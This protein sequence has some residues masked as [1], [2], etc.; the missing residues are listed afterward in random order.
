VHENDFPA[1]AEHEIG[2]S[3][4]IVPMKADSVS[5]PMQQ[6]PHGEFGLHALAPDAPH[7]LGSALWR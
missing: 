2:L 4:Q 5:E 6:P 1:R 3:R 7:I